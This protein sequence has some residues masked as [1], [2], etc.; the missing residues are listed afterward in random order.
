LSAPEVSR[1]ISTSLPAGTGLT[2]V[3]C[4]LLSYLVVE[5]LQVTMQ[6]ALL[7]SEFVIVTLAT[8]APGK[9]TQLNGTDSAAA[10]VDSKPAITAKREIAGRDLMRF[11]KVIYP[12]P[13]SVRR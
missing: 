11:A 9:M 7:L 10:G 12:P 2:Q 4:G 1:H 3:I 13:F 5:N 8:S 6:D